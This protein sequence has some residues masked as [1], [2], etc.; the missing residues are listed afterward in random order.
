MVRQMLQDSPDALAIGVVIEPNELLQRGLAACLEKWNVHVVATSR[1]LERAPALVQAHDCDVLVVGVDAETPPDV[2][3]SK[4]RRVHKLSPRTS[5]VVLLDKS[6][7][8]LL[9]ATLAGGAFTAVDRR[10]SVAVV[11]ETVERALVAAV[12]NGDGLQ[13][14]RP[15]LTRR[16]LEILRLVSEGRSNHEV[17]RLL[18]V[19]D[20]T[21]KFHLAN[22]YRK[23]GVRNRFEA[24]QWAI[25]HGLVDGPEHDNVGDTAIEQG[26]LAAV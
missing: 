20:Q 5:T 18:W 2:V 22:T 12:P 13:C 6:D 1:E 10:A 16:E 14:A 11:A 9:D 19:T 15:R 21:V 26:K 3:Y 17:A 23:L 7:A 25:A 4:L 24:R 8:A